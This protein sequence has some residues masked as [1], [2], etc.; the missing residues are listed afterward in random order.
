MKGGEY[1]DE[2]LKKTI[3]SI[4]ITRKQPGQLVDAKSNNEIV[5]SI[6]NDEIIMH[7]DY[8]IKIVPAI[9]KS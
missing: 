5:V 6:S 7:N 8:E 2:I 4:L 3:D 9:L 1:V